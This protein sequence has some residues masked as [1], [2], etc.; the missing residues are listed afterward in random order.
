MRK[1]RARESFEKKIDAV[2]PQELAESNASQTEDRLSSDGNL[3]VTRLYATTCRAAQ[4]S[5]GHP[6]E[7]TT[8]SSTNEYE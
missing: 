7:T 5:N 3:P 6:N 1:P 8:R 2:S 4:P